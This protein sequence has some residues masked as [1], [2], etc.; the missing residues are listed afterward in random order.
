MCKE[1]EALEEIGK[2]ECLFKNRNTIYMDGEKVNSFTYKDTIGNHFKGIDTIKQALIKKQETE[3]ENAKL[4]GQVN[5]L[6]DVITEF[7]KILSIIKKKGLDYHSLSAIKQAKNF[8]E[9][10]ELTKSLLTKFLD[11]TEEEFDSLKEVF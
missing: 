6:T 7:Q 5:Y 8:E 10:K 11:Y 3:K 2:E 1:L 4:K 9:F